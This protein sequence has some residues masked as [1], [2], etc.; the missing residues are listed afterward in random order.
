M[1]Q[2]VIDNYLFGLLVKSSDIEGD[3]FEFSP[4]SLRFCEVS[5]DML[6]VPVGDC[7]LSVFSVASSIIAVIFVFLL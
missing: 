5:V 7:I 4:F 1:L 3:E 2:Q 6:F